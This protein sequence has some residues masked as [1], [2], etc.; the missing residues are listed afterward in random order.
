[1]RRSA[2]KPLV[3][4][5][6]ASAI[7]LVASSSDALAGPIWVYSIS[8]G[9]QPS[10]A[11]TITLTQQDI[12]HVLVS[13]DLL[14]GYGFVNTGGPHT[15]F[16]FNLSGSLTGLAVS[17]WG[18]TL[19]SGGSYTNSKNNSGTFSLNTA[20]GGDNTTFGHFNVAIDDSAGNGSSKG[21]F[22]DLI[23]T[24]TR[25]GSLST[26]DFTFNNLGYY[27]SADL[28]SNIN[29]G[30]TGSQ[31]WAEGID[32]PAK[33]PEPFTMSLFGAGLAGMAALRRRKS[34]SGAVAA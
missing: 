31:G 26:D 13:V 25:P 30:T 2:L 5:L 29:E 9:T 1:M 3:L 14:N 27:F 16:A 4:A 32:P 20:L 17:N 24:L 21:Y 15:P 19:T 22:S 34:N 7:A 12:N 18:G 28:S 6:A 8:S 33:V 11:G 10:N 23:F